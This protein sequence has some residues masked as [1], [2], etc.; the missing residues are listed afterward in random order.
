MRTLKASGPCVPEACGHAVTVEAAKTLEECIGALRLK[1]GI[2]D[3]DTCDPEWEERERLIIKARKEPRE[4]HELFARLVLLEPKVSEEIPYPISALVIRLNDENPSRFCPENNYW[5]LDMRHAISKIGIYVSTVL[6]RIVYY[7]RAI[8]W[9]AR[10]LRPQFDGAVEHTER[11]GNAA[12]RNHVAE[13]IVALLKSPGVVS[14]DPPESLRY[15]NFR[16][17]SW[18]RDADA[19]APTRP[20]MH[21]THSTVWDYEE[22]KHPELDNLDRALARVR[23]EHGDRLL[24]AYTMSQDLE[25]ELRRIASTMPELQILFDWVRDA[26][27]VI[28]L[29]QHMARAIFGIQ[30]AEHLIVRSVGR[31]GKD[32]F[33]NLMAAVLGLYFHSVSYETLCGMRDGESPAPQLVAARG[34]RVMGVRECNSQKMVSSVFKRVCDHQSE[35]N[36]RALYKNP[37]R[38]HPTAMP[39]LCTNNSIELTK[40]DMA[41]VMRMAFVEFRMIWSDNPQSANE[42]QCRDMAPLF[43]SMR[44][45]VFAMCRLTYKHLMKGRFMRN[46]GPMP[47]ACV[48]ARNANIT[49]VTAEKI[50]EVLKANIKP[51]NAPRFASKGSD[52]EA[53]FAKKM[54]VPRADIRTTLQGMGMSSEHRKSVEV[55]KRVSTAFYKF[56]FDGQTE[57]SWV[58]L[59]DAEQSQSSSLPTTSIR[60]L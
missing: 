5:M 55:G 39:V 37:V 20:D 49:D 1:S 43:N 12:F 50:L 31:G 27:T 6:K 18:D 35:M 53:F 19:L 15:L 4:P 13:T 7:Y 11:F 24:D 17:G 46:V 8:K 21:I 58:A 41:C 47:Q 26:S 36:G 22:F 56:K 2:D 48:D 52:V 10:E 16:N 29:L 40:M 59:V 54:E 33:L 57:P 34:K 60:W 9:L 51:V 30:M 28:Y 14:F 44:V 45:G 25:D 42:G 23:Q 32:T 3:W 38:F